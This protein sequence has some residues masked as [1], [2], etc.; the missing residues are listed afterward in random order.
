MKAYTVFLFIISVAFSAKAQTRDSIMPGFTLTKISNDSIVTKS[1]VK[2]GVKTMFVLFD[3]SCLQCKYEI[4][5]IGKHYAHFKNMHIYLVSMDDRSSIE[6][7]MASWGKEL[8]GKENV[9]VLH[10]TKREFVEKFQPTKFPAMYI[11]SEKQHLI[12]YFGGRKELN[13]VLE[14]IK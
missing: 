5:A 8:Q 10:D 7:F 14:A 4:E 9:T 12:R 11:Y 2:G 6:H 1:Q 3:T 13:D